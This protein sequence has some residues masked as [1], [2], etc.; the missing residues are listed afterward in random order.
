METVV[1]ISVSYLATGLI[2]T[3]IPFQRAP[4]FLPFYVTRLPLLKALL[5]GVF[6]SVPVGISLAVEGDVWG[7]CILNGTIF[8]SVAVL[9][10]MAM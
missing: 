2:R 4:L 7:E 6:L 1:L 10:F 5:F 3:M 9:L 8:A